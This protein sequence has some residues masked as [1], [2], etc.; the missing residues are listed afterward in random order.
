M[1][2]DEVTDVSN[3]EQLCIIFRLVDSDFKLYEKPVELIQVPKTDQR[4]LSSLFITY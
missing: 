4:L 1:I 3:T 2:A